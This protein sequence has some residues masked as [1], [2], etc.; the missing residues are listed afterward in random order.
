MYSTRQYP[1]LPLLCAA[2][3]LGTQRQDPLQ[4]RVAVGD[5]GGAVCAEA[6]QGTGE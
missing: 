5:A 6:V 2:G 1:N 3:G 4:D